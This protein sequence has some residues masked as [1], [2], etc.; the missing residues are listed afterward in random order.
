MDVR[1]KDTY[2]IDQPPL[3]VPPGKRRVFRRSPPFSLSPQKETR[4]LKVRKLRGELKPECK[5]ELE[6]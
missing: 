4:V 5:L 2:E 6:G 3:S 1:N